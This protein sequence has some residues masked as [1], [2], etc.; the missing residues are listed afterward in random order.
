[1]RSELIDL[2]TG[3]DRRA[4]DVTA[5]VARFVA[6]AGDGLVQVFCPHST[7]GIAIIETGAGSDDD[8]IELIDHLLPPTFSYRHV[9]GSPGHGADHV[10]PAII[11]PSVTLPVIGGELQLGTWQSVVFVD[12]NRDNPD[13]RM[14]LSFVPA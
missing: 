9:H 13:R 11:S 4:V 1:M 7:A 6:G 12:P 8:L 10:M 3:T 5:H 14:R 2:H